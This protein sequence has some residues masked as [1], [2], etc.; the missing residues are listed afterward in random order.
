M[1][2]LLLQMVGLVGEIG[3]IIYTDFS[4]FGCISGATF[5]AEYPLFVVSLWLSSAWIFRAQAWAANSP[6]TNRPINVE[7]RHII[8]KSGDSD[9]AFL[10][11]EH[12]TDRY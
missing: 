7:R 6:S 11:D 8:T 2:M 1:L 5:L 4:T 3:S 9:Y 10:S 12:A